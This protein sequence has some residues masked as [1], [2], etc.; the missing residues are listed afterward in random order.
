MTIKIGDRFAVKKDAFQWVL[1]ET[2]DSVGRDGKPKKST[3]NTY[4]PTLKTVVRAV[5]DAEAG[6]GDSLNAL[7]ALMAK[8]EESL[9]V[10]L[11]D[12]AKTGDQP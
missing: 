8:A 6:R 1:T 9:Y 12:A 2:Y 11:C 3:R 4:H 10:R 5:V 7:V